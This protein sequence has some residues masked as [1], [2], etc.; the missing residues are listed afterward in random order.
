MTDI[1]T[2]LC[3]NNLRPMQLGKRGMATLLRDPIAVER[4]C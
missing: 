2:A 4:L 1:L 3:V